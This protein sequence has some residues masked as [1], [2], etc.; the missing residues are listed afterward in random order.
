VSIKLYVE[1]GGDS[2]GLRAECRRGFAEFIRKGGLASRMPRVVACGGRQQA[3]DDF[4]VAAEQAGNQEA[5]M[6]LIDAEQPV[7]AGNPWEHLR[8]QAGWS[9]PAGATDQQCHLMV[10]VMESWFL[11]DVETLADF[12]GTGFLQNALPGNSNV[13]VVPKS[14]VLSGLTRA[15]GQ[16]RKGPY[17]KGKHSFSL[18]AKIDPAKVERGAPY[19]KRFLEALRA[20]AGGA[21]G[22]V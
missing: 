2:R 13:E 12:Y 9:R 10:Q 15:T 1:G 7:Q 11:C 18:L 6:L 4:R 22:S 21:G 16:T 17:S 5:P 3:Y 20:H 14:D 8:L 19:A